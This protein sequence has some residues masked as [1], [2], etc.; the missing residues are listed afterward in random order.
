MEDDDP[1]ADSKFSLV[2]EIYIKVEKMDEKI[3][4]S[5][6]KE[7]FPYIPDDFSKS[8]TANEWNELFNIAK[9]RKEI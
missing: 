5:E 4:L 3:D 6:L 1:I 9:I 7:I 2:A 8:K